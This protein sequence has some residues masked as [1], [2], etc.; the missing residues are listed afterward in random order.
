VYPGTVLIV[1]HDRHLIRNV[2]EQVLEVRDGHATFHSDVEEHLFHPGGSAVAVGP[3]RDTG[4]RYER[5]T[6]KKRQ[7]KTRN[8]PADAAVAG[9]EARQLKR[10]VDKL[11][12]KVQTLER[13]LSEVH[14]RLADAEVYAD[15]EL[16][17]DLIDRHETIE[18]RLHRTMAEWEAAAE[19]LG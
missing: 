11:E 17:H 5:K 12:L 4:P 3:P 7:A 10:M 15:P 2:A 19:K 1:S 13:E 18:R 8:R 9:N 6:E 16:M 14:S